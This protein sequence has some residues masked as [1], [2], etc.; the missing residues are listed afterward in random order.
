MFNKVLIANRGEI[1][2]RI[3]R[4]CREMGIKT[5]AVYSQAD[6]QSL[7]VR[8]ADQAVCIGPAP[9]AKS[10]LNPLAILSAA[11]ITGADAI[12]PGFGF[13]SENEDFAK[14][15]EQ[16]GMVFIGPKPDSIAKMGDKS[17]AKK[18]MVA[19][20]MPVIPGSKGE[21]DDPDVAQKLAAEI[22]Y[23]VMIK[24][25][26]GGGGKGMRIAHDEEQLK[27]SFTM[28]RNEAQAAF[29]NGAV[30][31]EKY[32]DSPKHIEIQ[33]LGDG[34]G[35]VV[36]LGD[37]DCSVQRRHQ[38]LIEEAP[39][40][41]TTPELREKMGAAAIK[42]CSALNYRGAGTLEFLVDEKNNFYFMEMN[43]RIQVE[44][45]VTEM[46]TGLDIVREMIM[47]SAE[48]KLGIRQSDVMLRG[49][50]IECRIN[51]EDPD[52]NFM[53]TPGMI[54]TWHPPGGPGVRLDSHCY[55]EY[56]VPPN[57]DSMLA[58]LIVWAPNRTLAIARMLRALDEFQVEGVKTTIP[59]HRK[60]M[61]N[62]TFHKG[63]FGTNFIAKYMAPPEK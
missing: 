31:L 5:V 23:P 57:Y 56:V 29:G 32:I 59:F 30:Y 50:S 9:S 62:G 10:Y 25:S 41:L 52:R 51:A 3:I 45:T 40:A 16:C 11:E 26:A 42:A 24:A 54:K 22:G 44:H 63:T 48:G 58:K 19:A 46:V 39:G 47:V 49:H 33:V 20:N 27:S 55:E 2:L 1:A 35:H 61:Q 37:R 13:L 6:A 14:L 53:P 43:T 8:F 12:H 34:K 38:K 15:C 21:V 17:M 7:H 36:H 28:A 18:T 4:T 60:V